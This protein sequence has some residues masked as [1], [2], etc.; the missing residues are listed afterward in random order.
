MRKDW[1]FCGVVEWQCNPTDATVPLIS[2]PG[3]SCLEKSLPLSVLSFLVCSLRMVWYIL[4]LLYKVILAELE[5]ISKA[6]D[7][8]I[9]L[10]LH[11]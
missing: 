4:A 3:C 10:E 1:V 7:F 11:K 5:K 2:D 9:V 6:S 8:F